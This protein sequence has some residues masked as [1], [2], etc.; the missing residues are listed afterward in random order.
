MF[1]LVQLNLSAVLFSYNLVSS[2]G[3]WPRRGV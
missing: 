3:P 1:T 2:P